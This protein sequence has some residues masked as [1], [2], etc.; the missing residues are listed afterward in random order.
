MDIQKLRE[1][2]LANPQEF[3]SK[4]NEADSWQDFCRFP[5]SKTDRKHLRMPDEPFVIDRDVDGKHMYVVCT[6]SEAG[7]VK[8]IAPVLAV[9]ELPYGVWRNGYFLIPDFGA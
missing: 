9:D 4:E 8:H 1:Y 2:I 5:T 3:F 7:K 6:I